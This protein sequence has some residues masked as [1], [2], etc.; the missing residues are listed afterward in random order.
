MLHVCS[1]FDSPLRV[2]VLLSSFTCNLLAATHQ[3]L[4]VAPE[5]VHVGYWEM[6][7]HGE[8]CWALKQAAQGTRGVTVPGGV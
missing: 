6:F 8:W 2:H 5:E 3:W 7:L 4:R 1:V